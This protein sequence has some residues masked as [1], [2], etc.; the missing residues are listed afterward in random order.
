MTPRVRS[1]PGLLPTGVIRK[2]SP[3]KRESN[4]QERGTFNRNWGRVER[5]GP[6]QGSDQQEEKL[7]E[8]L[9]PEIGTVK[10]GSVPNSA[11]SAFGGPLA[12]F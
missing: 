11:L 2:S 7:L 4:G 6:K 9:W 8:A 1:H 12:I 10:L 3:N 5:P